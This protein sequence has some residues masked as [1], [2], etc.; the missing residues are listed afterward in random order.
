MTSEA[1][2]F[3]PRTRDAAFNLVLW[4]VEFDVSVKLLAAELGCH[5]VMVTRWRTGQTKPGRVYALKLEELTS[6]RVSAVSWGA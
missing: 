5:P 2:R 3:T 1:C 6:G 4:M